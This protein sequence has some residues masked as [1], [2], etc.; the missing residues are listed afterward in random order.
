M[1]PPLTFI[2][3]A[4]TWVPSADGARLVAAPNTFSTSRRLEALGREQ[5]FARGEGLPGRA[6]EL[7][8]PLLMQDL[9]AAYF[10]RASA[11][12]E[13]G[14]TCAMA[15]PIILGGALKAVLVLFCGHVAGRCDAL[16]LW[17]V[18]AHLS[19]DMHWVDGAYGDGDPAFAAA[20]RSTVLARGEGL[21]GT[22]WQRGE[23]QFMEDLS[24]APRFKRASQAGEAGLRRG[25]AIPFGAQDDSGYV[26][27]LLAGADLPLA[28]AIERWEPDSSKQK[29]VRTYA[30]SERQG[31]RVSTPAELGLQDGE[32]APSA[33]AAA[34]ATGMPTLS[35]APDQEP[36][37]VASTASTVG[38]SALLALPVIWGGSVIRGVMVLYL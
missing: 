14:I 26:V 27:A 22:A 11:A 4:E 17:H 25:L 15:V 19:T 20:S 31:G 33:V 13:A 24:T 34:Y 12:Q 5:G 9:G 29:L 32:A 8:R 21:P 7:G 2:R 3:A 1:P 30:F 16:E 6:W 35:D 37:P 38:A 28:L 18:D 23:I 10:Q 36:G